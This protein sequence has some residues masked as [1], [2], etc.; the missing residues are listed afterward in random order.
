MRSVVELDSVVKVLDS[1]AVLNGADLVVYEGQTLVIIGCSG[2]GKSVTLKHIVG[3]MEPDEGQVRVFGEVISG[4]HERIKNRIRLKIGLVFQDGAL[5]DF[6]NVYDNVAF[7]LR[8][9]YSLSEKEVNQKVE[10]AL[11]L[12]GLAGI[13]TKMPSELSGGMRKRVAIARAIVYKPRLMLYD[14]PTAG[15]DPIRADA[16]DSLILRLRNEA[17]TTS[18]VVTHDLNSAYKIAD[19][20]CMLHEGKFIIDGTPDDIRNTENPIVRQ[21]I[22]G[23][24]NGPIRF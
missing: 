21:F 4:Q 9:I 13:E 3:L 22:E 17:K 15:L 6:M 7:V 23:K 24:S 5:F 2:T 19:R 14:E 18:I 10:W 8:E 12:V 16:I 20:I 1:K 11:A